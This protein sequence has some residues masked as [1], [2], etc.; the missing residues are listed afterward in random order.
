MFN[1]THVSFSIM[2][3]TNATKIILHK[4]YSIQDKLQVSGRLDVIGTCIS[5]LLNKKSLGITIPIINQSI[6]LFSVGQI[7]LL[8]ALSPQSHLIYLPSAL[9][10]LNSFGNELFVSHWIQSVSMNMKHFLDGFGG[11]EGSWWK[12]KKEVCV[13]FS[14]CL[15]FG[16]VYFLRICDPIL[17]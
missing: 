9:T 16:L 17:F 3:V 1:S 14:L 4:S 13:M 15:C 12:D 5:Q 10:G 8:L 6:H 2:Y 11:T 7:F